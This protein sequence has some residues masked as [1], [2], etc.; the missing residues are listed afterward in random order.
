MPPSDCSKSY[1]HLRNSQN[2]SSNTAT[3]TV[4]IAAADPAG[5]GPTGLSGV[6]VNHL[7]PAEPSSGNTSQ[8]SRR[9]GLS[10][11]HQ[12]VVASAR[13]RLTLSLNVPSTGTTRWLCVESRACF[14]LQSRQA[15]HNEPAAGQACSCLARVCPSSGRR[16][17]PQAAPLHGGLGLRRC[18]IPTEDVTVRSWSRGGSAGDAAC[19]RNRWAGGKRL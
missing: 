15:V 19:A 17:C 8:H 14:S 16:V 7:Q 10:G 11:T 4:L 3:A 13:T 5:R 2:S 1:F 18:R 9:G 6:A 12:R